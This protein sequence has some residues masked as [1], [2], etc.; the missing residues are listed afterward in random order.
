MHLAWARSSRHDP[1][2]PLMSAVR[3]LCLLLL[4]GASL[5]LAPAC[6]KDPDKGF[7][8]D[9]DFLPPKGSEGAEAAVFDKNNVADTAALEDF[10]AL[11]ATLI[12][13]FLHRTPYDR[14]SFLETYQSNGT[15]ASDAIAR[16]ARTYRIN[17]LAFLVAAQGTQGLI[18]E[19]NYPFPPERVEYVFRCGCLQGT[20]CLPELAGFD[21]Q[22]DCLGRQLRQALE[23]INTGEETT[24]GWAKDKTS[25][26]LDNQKVTPA[27]AG[28]AVVYDRSP[29]V[30]EGAAG[31]TWFFWNLFNVYAAGAPGGGYSGPVGGGAGGAWVGDKCTS[32]AS[33]SGLDNA[34][35][36]TDYPDG[37][38]TTKCKGDCPSQPDKPEAFCADFKS[39]GGYCLPVCNLT[40]ASSCRTGYKCT[41]TKKF[42]STAAADAKPVCSLK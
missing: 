18:G 37:L 38:C 35:C 3:G 36:A 25:L 12:Q 24:G 26:T 34:I 42:G 10:E 23:Q 5:A 6:K 21:R 4:V 30:A 1:G 17:P 2:N 7:F 32:V 14:P 19:V 22:I 41:T 29:R 20:D 39:N 31:G 16:A 15:R 13:Q 8:Q 33:C 9:Q 27:N 40:S 28:T 11:D